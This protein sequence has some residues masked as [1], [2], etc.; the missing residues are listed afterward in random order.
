MI[1]YDFRNI[2][3]IKIWIIDFI[4]LSPAHLSLHW[5]HSTWFGVMGKATVF[6]YWMIWCSLRGFMLIMIWI[7]LIWLSSLEDVLKTS[8]LPDMS[9]RYW[10]IGKTEGGKEKKLFWCFVVFYT[11]FIKKK[12]FEKRCILMFYFFIANCKIV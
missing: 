10:C 11:K 9:W 2:K 4:T 6:Y 3:E 7:V 8:Y 1:I 12:I 5:H